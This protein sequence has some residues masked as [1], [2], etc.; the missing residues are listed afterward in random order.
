[1]K[2]SNFVGRPLTPAEQVSIALATNPDDTAALQAKRAQYAKAL[3]YAKAHLHDQFANTAQFAKD[4][5]TLSGEI[6]DIDQ[7]LAG[8]AEE[9]ARKAEEARARAEA[10]RRKAE[11]ARLALIETLLPASGVS[12]TANVPGAFERL[13]TGILPQ[14][15]RGKSIAD[16][17]SFLGVSEAQ[18]EAELRTQIAEQS[19]KNEKKLIPY[20]EQE[21]TA[22]AAQAKLLKKIGASVAD[23]LQ[24]TLNLAQ[25]RRRIRDIRAQTAA[26]A[27]SV[28]DLFGEGGNQF[29]QYGSNVGA[30]VQP[31]SRGEAGGATV[32]AA[33]QIVV[34]QHFYGERNAAQAI[35]EASQA[36]RALK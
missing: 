35:A 16:I 5:E 18:R 1:V 31:L 32:R 33:K 30:L 13:R 10:A 19:V 28:Q 26:D 7:H 34:N 36:A 20:L 21:A 25:I 6:Y 27:F 22:A 23:Q 15:L 12:G 2:G 29:A 9:N 3:A 4:I 11:A 24:A 8:I 17:S 14:R